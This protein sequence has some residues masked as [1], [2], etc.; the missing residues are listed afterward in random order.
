MELSWSCCDLNVL[1]GS[2]A[3]ICNSGDQ[4]SNDD[5]DDNDKVDATCAQNDINDGE[6][7]VIIL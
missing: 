1:G 4:N 6:T 2:E 3:S 7:D 5:D